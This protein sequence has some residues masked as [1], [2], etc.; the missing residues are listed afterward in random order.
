MKRGKVG[1]RVKHRGDERRVGSDARIRRN[2]VLEPSGR[3]AFSFL[4]TRRLTLE[5][6]AI[7]ASRDAK[8]AFRNWKRHISSVYGMLSAPLVVGPFELV[9]AR[10][11]DSKHDAL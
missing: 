5:G 9:L 3:S 1:E 2:T 7:G 6:C 8:G 10:Q 4:V 11:G